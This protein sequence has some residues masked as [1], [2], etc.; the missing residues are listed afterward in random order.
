MVTIDDDGIG[1]SLRAVDAS[2]APFNP[3]GADHGR[4]SGRG[5]PNMTHRAQ[6][7]GGRLTWQALTTGSRLTLW[8]PLAQLSANG[9]KGVR[10][11]CT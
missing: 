8:L 7:I 10:T 6:A 11:A 2:D 3:A 1:T 4:R 9:P 5:L